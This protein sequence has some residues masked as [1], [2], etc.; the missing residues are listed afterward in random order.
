L[1]AFW[2]RTPYEPALDE[3]QH[4]NPFR[5]RRRTVLACKSTAQDDHVVVGPHELRA[6]FLSLNLKDDEYDQ[7]GDG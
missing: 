7:A 3:A 5:Q 6:V 1:A 2:F 4:A